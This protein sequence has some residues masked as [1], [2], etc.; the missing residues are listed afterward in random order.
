[1][2]RQNMN[3]KQIRKSI[4]ILLAVL[5]LVTVTAGAVSASF[6]I[7]GKKL[8]KES[9]VSAIDRSGKPTDCPPLIKEKKLAGLEV[10]NKGSDDTYLITTMAV[11]RDRI[12]M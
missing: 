12:I 11:P 7:S 3:K 1:M 9:A 8:S 4:A 10:A 6:S 2:R 5:F